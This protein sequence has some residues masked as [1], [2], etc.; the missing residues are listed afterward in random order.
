LATI[1]ASKGTGEISSL[2]LHEDATAKN[3]AEYCRSDQIAIDCGLGGSFASHDMVTASPPVS[4][5]VV[6]RILTIQIQTLPGYLGN[7]LRRLFVHLVQKQWNYLKI[8][9]P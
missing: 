1:V 3:N 7:E 2:D 4:P 5:N 6:A 9:C 8:D